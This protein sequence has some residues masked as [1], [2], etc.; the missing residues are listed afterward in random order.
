MSRLRPA[1]VLAGVGGTVLLGSLWLTWYGF[2]AGVLIGPGGDAVL[3]GAND[4]HVPALTAWEAFSVT[5]VLL[6]LFALL[7]IG[8]PL[9]SALARGPAKPVAFTVLGSVGGV[10]AVL[11]VLYRL[12]DQPGSNALVAVKAGAW[13][14]LAGAVLTLVGCWLAMADDR[15]PGAAPPQ[16]PRRPAP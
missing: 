7:A 14:G 16:V 9:T 15:T 3:F 11:L 10:L 4:R 13:I 8:V 6:A 5:D 12:L 1:D 2:A